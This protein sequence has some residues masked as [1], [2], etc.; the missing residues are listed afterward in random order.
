MVEI[1][2]AQKEV[3]LLLSGMKLAEVEFGNQQEWKASKAI[4]K[5]YD[6]LYRQ[7]FTYGQMKEEN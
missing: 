5:L 7:I 4:S 3:H 1:E 6:T 2:L